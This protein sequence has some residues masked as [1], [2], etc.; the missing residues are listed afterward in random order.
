MSF[1]FDNKTITLE[2]YKEVFVNCSPDILDEVRLAILDDTPIGDFIVHCGADSYKLSQF[3]KAIREL[4]PVEFLKPCLSAEIIGC[5]RYGISKGYDM[6]ELLKY[7]NDKGLFIDL[8]S[9]SILAE[10]TS[11]GVDISS[12]DFTKVPK[13]Q[14][15]AFC[16]GL[17]HHYPMWLLVSDT[18]VSDNRLSLLMRGMSLGIDVHPFLNNSW[19]DDVIVLLFSKVKK[20]DI[21]ALLSKITPMFDKE[22][23]NIIL[24]LAIKGLAYDSLCL[25][26]AEGYPLFN[27]YQMDIISIAIEEGL[28]TN[29]MLNPNIS[30]T[31]IHR[32]L[33]LELD[34]R[35]RVLS[36]SLKKKH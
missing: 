18:P 14:V 7:V 6:S 26:D 12:V 27:S 28:L 10:F 3:R 22:K 4:V 5:I 8:K 20:C 23:I 13:S 2:N 35:E 21:N 36:V 11:V 1:R 31:E 19:S 17:W 29:A 32:L 30:D 34:K 33:E 9:L 15:E 16:K 24:N 25:K